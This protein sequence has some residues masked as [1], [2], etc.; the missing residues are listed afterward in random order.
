M[1]GLLEGMV[2]LVTGAA[3]GIGR[4][5]A[6]RFADE[7]AVAIVVADVDET[8]GRAT[9]EEIR[10]RGSDGAFARCD[11]ADYGQVAAAVDLALSRFGRL[12]GAYNNAGLGHGQAPIAEID[13]AGWDR[14]VAVN[15][16]GTW[17]C[18][19]HELLAM[20]E[21]GSGAIVNQSS[22]TGIVGWPLVGGYGATKAAIAH[23]TKIAAAEYADRGIRINAIAPG[24]IATDMVARAIAARPEVEQH[25]NESVPMGRIGQPDE[26]AEVAAWL[27]S[28]R[29]S[30][31]T[32]ATIPVD[33]GQTSKG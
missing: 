5:S 23:L 4:A 17:H 32:G 1:A 7:G 14:T 10:R 9:V 15:L 30:Y 26:V 19:K 29:S 33:G 3:A 13:Q 21:L 31:V 6:L 16:T 12:D 25:I 2:V 18:M 28:P 20:V 11:V 8:G 24:P 27:L 22:A